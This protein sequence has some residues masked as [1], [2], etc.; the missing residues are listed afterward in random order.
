MSRKPEG[1]LRRGWTTGAC[2]AAAA[3]GAYEALLTGRLPERVT[4]AVPRGGHP[5]AALGT[6]SMPG[7]EALAMKTMNG[8]LGIVGGLSILGT[9]GVVIPYSCASWIHAI[10]SGIDVAR[11]AGLRHVAGATGRGSEKAV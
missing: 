7:G 9:T 4:V 2:A 10:H 8:R 5:G 11:A 6:V 1:P 3:R